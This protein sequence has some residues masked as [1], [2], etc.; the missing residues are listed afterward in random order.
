M[1]FTRSDVFEMVDALFHMYASTYRNDAK[2]EL[3][4]MIQRREDTLGPPDQASVPGNGDT[5]AEMIENNE[6]SMWFW[7]GV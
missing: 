3:A 5:I 7:A 1:K 2:E 4:D 6:E